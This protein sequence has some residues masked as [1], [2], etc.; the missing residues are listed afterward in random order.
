MLPA[1]Y[2]SQINICAFTSS[3]P[4]V[5]LIQSFGFCSSL[6]V[7][8]EQNYNDVAPYLLSISV[9]LFVCLLLTEELNYF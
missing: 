3:L 8:F 6:D 1:F 5:E 9:C 4:L 7:G 2:D